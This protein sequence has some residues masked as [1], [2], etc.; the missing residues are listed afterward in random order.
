M[1][2]NVLKIQLLFASI[3]ELLGLVVVACGKISD[4]VIHSNKPQ[5]RKAVGLRHLHVSLA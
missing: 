1:N 3:T 5:V 4:L 2:L